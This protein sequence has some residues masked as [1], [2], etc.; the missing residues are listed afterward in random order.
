MTTQFTKYEAIEYLGQVVQL[1]KRWEKKPGYIP[2]DLDLNSEELEFVKNIPTDWLDKGDY[3]RVDFV[4]YDNGNISLTL[5]GL[6]DEDLRSFDKSDFEEYC[7]VLKAEA[8]NYAC[9]V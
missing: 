5:S 3:C 6:H 7:Q 8:I 1:K 2:E 9:S 4:E